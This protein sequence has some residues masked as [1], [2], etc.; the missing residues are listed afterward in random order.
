MR[1]LRTGKRRRRTREKSGGGRFD[2]DLDALIAHQLDACPAVRATTA[3][4]PSDGLRADDHWMQ[5]HADLARLLGGAAL[6]L[7]L[8]AQRTRAAV[9]HAGRIHHAQAAIGFSTPL[10]GDERVP[11]W[12]S[13]GPIGLERKVGSGEAAHFPGSGSG[14]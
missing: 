4:M 14:R 6:P 7:A 12:A 13:E 1:P 2:L 9:A 5:Q 11:C 3:V 8:L 10:M